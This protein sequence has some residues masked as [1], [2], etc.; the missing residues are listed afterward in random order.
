MQ[1]KEDGHYKTRLVGRGCQHS[2]EIGFKEIFSQ[3]VDKNT[4]RLIFL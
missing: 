1:L 2:K 4:L 3:V